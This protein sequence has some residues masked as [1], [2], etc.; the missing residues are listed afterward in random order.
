MQTLALNRAEWLITLTSEH[1]RRLINGVAAR[2]TQELKTAT[3]FL[4]Q[5]RIGATLCFN[6]TFVDFIPQ[7]F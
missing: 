2:K 5:F 1:K 4:C 7:R 6:K 3:E